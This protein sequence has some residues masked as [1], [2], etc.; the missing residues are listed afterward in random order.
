MGGL[1]PVLG[2]L[3]VSGVQVN[4]RFLG[5]LKKI[6]VK[7]SK[8]FG[9][10]PQSREKRKYVLNLSQ[11]YINSYFTVIISA[12]EIDYS[13]KKGIKL[14]D[15]EA[16]AVATILEKLNW[17]K[18]QKIYIH[19]LGQTSK[20]VFLNKMDKKSNLFNHRKFISKMLYEKDADIKYLPVSLGFYCC[21]D[22]S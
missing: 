13:F 5:N 12:K 20:E 19:Q 6:G 15:L 9:G 14:Y 11:E 18:V 2:P 22:Y 10:N 1:A 21:K 3:V 17:E 4:K 8:M 16:S 7:D